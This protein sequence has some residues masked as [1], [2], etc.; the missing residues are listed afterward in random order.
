M[1]YKKIILF[2]AWILVLLLCFFL[3]L[4]LTSTVIASVGLFHYLMSIW[5]CGYFFIFTGALLRE[6]RLNLPKSGSLKVTKKSVLIIVCMALSIVAY[7]ETMLAPSDMSVGYLLLVGMGS[8][9]FGTFGYTILLVA[10]EM[11][12]FK[13]KRGE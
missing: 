11:K 12:W 4:R 2:I 10:N 9:G 3:V 8:L 13:L 5:L 1:N 7:L 6:D